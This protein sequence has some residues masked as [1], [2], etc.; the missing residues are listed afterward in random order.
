MACD[1]ITLF[2]LL[3]R[4]AGLKRRRSYGIDIFGGF[5]PCILF[6]ISFHPL[7]T[8]LKIDTVL[9]SNRIKAKLSSLASRRLGGTSTEVEISH[10]TRFLG[11]SCRELMIESNDCHCHFKML[12]RLCYAFSRF[13]SQPTNDRSFLSLASANGFGQEK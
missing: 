8:E 12:K 4:P 7:K 9:A 3:A 6:N 5:F 13:Q 11:V 2:S 1:V 10:A